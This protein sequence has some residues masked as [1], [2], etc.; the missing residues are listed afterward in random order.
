MATIRNYMRAFNG[1]I[2]SPSMYARIDDGKYQTGSL[3]APTS[4][5]NRRGLCASGL[6][7]ST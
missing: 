4:W 7:L 1:G 6:A 2:V 5:S 3:S